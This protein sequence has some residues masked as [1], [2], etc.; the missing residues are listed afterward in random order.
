M[1]RDVIGVKVQRDP[2]GFHPPC[3]HTTL[4]IGANSQPITAR[5]AVGDRHVNNLH[6]NQR[7]RGVAASRDET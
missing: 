1:A 6:G 7:L 5:V 4:T 2:L 3:F